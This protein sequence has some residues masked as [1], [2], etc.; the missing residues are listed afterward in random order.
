MGRTRWLA[1]LLLLGCSGAAA[2][3]ETLGDRAYAE[4][5]YSDA[6]VE[7]RLALGRKAPN[8]ALQAK[9][10]AAALNVG[11]LTVAAQAYGALAREGG[12]G[13]A[14]EAADGLARVVNT[15][16]ADGDQQGLASALTI[17]QEVAPGRAAGSFAGQIVRATRSVTSSSEGLALLLYAAAGARDAR[18]QDSLMFAYGELL[19]RL[20]R[21]PDALGVYESLAR[22]GREP[23]VLAPSQQG[24]A[25]CALQLGN[26]ALESG[27]PTA[28]E[29]WFRRA[30]Q[31][32]G[33][34]PAARAAYIGLGDVRF[35]QGDYAAAADAYERARAG[36][37]PAD[38]LFGIA[39][40]RLNLLGRIQ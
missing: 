5:R 24:I 19:R 13:R 12:G 30:V 16:L 10:A 14:G 21:C 6:L 23:A 37:T 27:Q 7:Y 18:A 32:G 28:A 38:S 33:D 31:G 34:A 36:L 20:N 3:H 15:A 9:M 40:Q 1:V 39:S 11:D 4:R 25:L 8:P 26:Q 29:D 22:R 35:A 2:D 17:L